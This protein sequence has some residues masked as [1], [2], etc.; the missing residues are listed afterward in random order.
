MRIARPKAC[1]HL[2]PYRDGTRN[3]NNVGR[4]LEAHHASLAEPVSSLTM[5][6]Y[7]SGR[8]CGFV[9]ELENYTKVR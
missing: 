2:L 4:M 9:T 7:D 5:P 6:T 8:P 1:P 3:P